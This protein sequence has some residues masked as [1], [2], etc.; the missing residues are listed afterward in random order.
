MASIETDIIVFV[1]ACLLLNPSPLYDKTSS[2]TRPFSS[3][4]DDDD[5]G[6]DDGG[7]DV[8]DNDNPDLDPPT[9]WQP[10]PRTCAHREAVLVLPSSP[11]S[12]GDSVDATLYNPLAPTPLTSPTM[13][14][15]QEVYEEIISSHQ[16]LERIPPE[17]HLFCPRTSDDDVEDY[18]DP[19]YL[20]PDLTP[21]TRERRQKLIDDGRRR[22]QLTSWASLILGISA[23]QADRW[24]GDWI[25]RTETFL[26]KCDSCIRAWHMERKA[27]KGRLLKEFDEMTANIMESRLHEFDT[28]RIKEGL[29]RAVA[30]LEANGPMT[31][32]KLVAYDAPAVLA[33]YEALCCVEFL[34]LPDNRR[35]FNYVFQKTQEKKILKIATAVIPSMTVFLFQADPLRCTF[36]RT[37]WERC[38]PQSITPEQFEWAVNDHLADAIEAVS[39][40]EATDADIERF[41]DGFLLLL[42]AMSE[43]RVLHSLRGMQIPVDVYQLAVKHTERPSDQVLA[44]VL[45]ALCALMDKS[46]KAFW[47]ALSLMN[48][49]Q[50]PMFVCASP[51]FAPFLALSFE[52]H[53]QLVPDNSAVQS[54]AQVPLLV[55]FVRSLMRSLNR[56]QRADVCDYFLTVFLTSSAA[57]AVTATREG[58]ST[59]IAAGLN[60]LQMTLDG[61]LDTRYRLTSESTLFVNTVINNTVK[62]HDYVVRSANLHPGDRYNIGLSQAAVGVI[63]SA[64]ALDTRAIQ[65][66]W[67]VLQQNARPPPGGSE[68]RSSQLWDGFRSALAPGRIDLA[69]VMLSA[70]LSLRGIQ[71]FAPKKRQLVVEDASKSR[72]NSELDNAAEAIASTVTRIS[73]TLSRSDLQQLVY[74]DAQSRAM[75][76]V[77]ATLVHAEDSIREAGMQLVMTLVDND[78][79]SEAIAKMVYDYPI[80]FLNS[81]ADSVSYL[82]GGDDQL[83]SHQQSSSSSSAAS[84]PVSLTASSSP[85]EPMRLIFRTS[86]DILNSLCD[87]SSGLLR[88]RSLT[89]EEQRAV[90]RW[91][92]MEWQ[93]VDHSFLR[94]RAWSEG[95]EKA[96]MENYCRDVMEFAESLIEQDG[97]IASALGDPASGGSSNSSSNSSSKNT[98]ASAAADSPEPAAS[99]PGVSAPS[100]NDRSMLSVLDAPR[101]YSMGLFEMIQLRD[102]YLVNIIVQIL[103]KLFTRLK[104]YNMSFPDRF[105]NSIRNTYKPHPQFRN[106]FTVN[107]NLNDT[108]RAELMR[109]IGDGAEDDAD[110]SVEIISWSKSGSSSGAST[111]KHLD[112]KKKQTSL[113]AWSRAGVGMGSTPTSAKASTLSSKDAASQLTPGLN[114]HRALLDKFKTA[115]GSTSAKAEI[116][117]PAPIKPDQKALIANRAAI[118]EAR[119]RDKAE[120]EKHKAEA[121]A[122]ARALRTNATKSDIMVDSEEEE[123]EDDDDDDDDGAETLNLLSKKGEQQMDEAERRRRRNLQMAPQLPVKKIKHLRSAKDMRARIIPDMTTLHKAILEWDIFH[124]GN[125]PPNRRQC[126]AVADSYLSPAVYKGTFF[127][128]LI[129]EAWRSFVT[130]KD[131]CTNKPFEIT[132]GLRASIDQFV[133]VSTVMKK[134]SSGPGNGHASN[135]RL[136]GEGDIVLVS[137]S[138]DPLTGRADLHCLARVWKTAHKRGVLE[139]TYRININAGAIL[140]LIV[141]GAQFH[142]VKITNMTT[143]ER[144]YA[145]LESLQYYDLMDEVLKATPSPMLTFG[146]AAITD[147]QKNY[148]LNRGQALAI[149]HGKANDGFTLVQGPPG[150]GKTKTIVAM[151]GALLTGTIRANTNAVAMSRPNLAQGGAGNDTTSKKLLVCAPS[152]A[153]VDELVLRLKAGIKETTGATRKINVLRLGRSDAINASVRDVTL[154]ELVKAEL[155]RQNSTT[156]TTIGKDGKPVTTTTDGSN[157]G[158]S[159]REQIHQRAGQIKQR[160]GELKPIIDEARGTVEESTPRIIE[161]QRENDALRIEQRGVNAAIERDKESGNT[162]VRETEIKRRQIQQKIL[163]EAHVLCATLSGSGHDLFKN[164]NIEFET[165]I[166]DEAAQCV[167]LSALIPL[168]YGCSKCVLVGDPKQLPPTVLSQSAAKYGYDQSLFVR[169]Q[170]NR[171]KDVHLLDTQY[172]MHPEISLFPS[173]QFYEGRLFDGGDM[174]KLRREPWHGAP[175][176]PSLLGP[177]RFFD[178]TGEQSRGARGQ[179]L[180]NENEVRV[181]L[182]LYRRFMEVASHSKDGGTF[183]G[184]IGIITPY[185]A[186]LFALRQ[187]FADQYG[188]G[189]LD[190]VD[191]NTTDAFQGRECDIIIF[192]CVRASPTGGIGFMTD[193]RRM[194]VGL[195]RARSSLWILGDSRALRQGEFWRALIEDAKD[196]NRYTGGNV[197]ALLKAGGSALLAPGG[198]GG[199]GSKMQIEERKS[200]VSNAPRDPKTEAKTEPKIEPKTEPKKPKTE[201]APASPILLDDD[202]DEDGYSPP[203]AAAPV[204]SK[205]PPPTG[206]SRKKT[207]PLLPTQYTLVD[208]PSRPPIP[209]SAAGM[210]GINARGEPLPYGP[211]SSSSSRPAIVATSGGGGSGPPK[212]RP[213]DGSSS[214]TSEQPP[215]RSTG[216]V[217]PR[218]PARRPTDP[219]AM[220]VLGING[221]SRGPPPG[222]PQGPSR[223]PPPGA[224]QAPRGAAQGPRAPRPPVRPPVKKPADPFIKRKPNKRQ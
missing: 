182:Q 25:S 151:V 40:P 43:E 224:P 204:D 219:S 71:R 192:S 65:D 198:S 50:L 21:E 115:A 129:S 188:P 172:R 119:A 85:Y 88:S 72:F 96:T 181:A 186:Q 116:K 197:L 164:L 223:G 81:F 128:L 123:E 89:A 20:S 153:A 34:S 46:S 109:A 86:R 135:D 216:H 53:M 49:P 173:Q 175:D 127:P 162:Y 138:Q 9:L 132:I 133:E 139:V 191:F 206:P 41:W 16:E 69:R 59:C 147:V 163:N 56:N 215:K 150:T 202:D 212:K 94:A 95:V 148:E 183:Q 199:G 91:W 38:P 167:E 159:N 218:P 80:A 36:A 184:K 156:I 177:Y 76:A 176:K 187:R 144:E 67:M 75:D 22:L 149:L 200:S 143:I 12:D 98:A 79:R 134:P 121:I 29:Q 114:K 106:K 93:F 44:R 10:L 26:V 207:A 166:I 140:P 58:H 82:T 174:A 137:R 78:T 17:A 15:P 5:G 28:K 196:R 221:T 211:S 73:E 112:A 39:R 169:M 1:S 63:E 37:A 171:P 24:L 122:K 31:S 101:K 33:Y 125:D 97:L 145:A 18:D 110:D 68:R 87:A 107:T 154:E 52:P 189:V 11:P 8:N 190:T 113:E 111:P 178:V 30:V 141:K 13:K 54:R 45:R 131:E 7:D 203:P 19:A 23:E 66:E 179:S 117:K 90:K 103:V 155:N 2:R 158:M 51:A 161:L 100:T 193:I 220:E 84:A 42:N 152:N 201:I 32:T 4:H 185:K 118:R 62:H 157:G 47:D 180:V 92:T 214:P 27:L 74:A 35:I 83:R 208:R 168:K 48:P 222:A 160:L 194:N 102:P 120:M 60:A 70:T 209:A 64:L 205:P 61:Y 77:A 146:D 213:H 126:A 105:V 165:V 108:Q 104:E 210:G 14:S 124:E 99:A 57:P 195:T 3:R 136:L 217:P 6:D 55:A 142:G 170:R 130:S